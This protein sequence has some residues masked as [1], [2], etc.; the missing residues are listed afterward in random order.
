MVA[1]KEEMDASSVSDE[2]VAD[3][4]ETLRGMVIVPGDPEYDEARR[5]WNGRVDKYPALVAR[6]TGAADVVTAVN[7]ARDRDLPL[8]IKSGGHDC[9]GSSVCDDGLVIDLSEMNGVRVDPR[10]ETVRVEGG[11]TWGDL[12]HETISFDLAT[13]GVMAPDVGVAGVTLGGGYGNLDR[14]HGLVVDNLRSADVVTAQGELVR[15]SEDEN[16]DLF[17]ALRGGGSNFG[18]VTS[19]EFDLH[20]GPS[21]ILY[22]QIVHSFDDAPEVLRSYREFM[23]NAPDEVQCNAAVHRFPAHPDVP[24]HLHGETGIML[25]PFYL[26]D[27]AEGRRVL[28]PLQAIGDPVADSLRVVS[29]DRFQSDAREFQTEGRRNYWR[30]LFVDRLSG[31]AIDTFVDYATPLPTTSSKITFVPLGGAIG[32]VGRDATAFPHRDAEFLVGIYPQWTDSDRDGEIV[33][34]TDDLYDALAEHSTG[35]EYVNNQSRLGDARA[36]AAYGDNYER[37]V[38]IKNEWDPDNLFRVNQNVTPTE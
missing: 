17:W 30:S 3:L 23:A 28:E 26:G 6:C 5:V 33:S 27:I 14:K 13:T 25:S 12:N 35:G 37:L 16:P 24:A 18:V 38:E 34:W 15:A 22:G 8:S 11:A 31:E 1:R 2:H 10:R 32:R 7:F 9:K 4:R 21:E 20:R 19:F 36:K 29:A